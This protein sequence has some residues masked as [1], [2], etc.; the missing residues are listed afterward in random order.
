MSDQHGRSI[1]R[2]WRRVSN[3][4]GFGR[5]TATDDTGGVHKAQIKLGQDEIRDATP[6]LALYGMHSHAPPGSDVTVLFNG[7]DRSNGLAIASGNQGARPRGTQAGEVALY[8]NQG[9]QVFIGRNGIRIVGAGLPVTIDAT[10]GCTINAAAGLTIN[11][12]AGV[13]IVGK[14]DVTQEVTAMKDGPSVTLSQHRHDSG[15][16]P[17][18]GT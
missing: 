9:Q 8:D 10:A 11:A 13:R 14:L 1:E 15:P 4:V 16:P 18:A 6:V 12:A 3:L 7:G 2:L 5:I 17:D